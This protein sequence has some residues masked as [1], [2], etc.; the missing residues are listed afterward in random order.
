MQV[1]LLVS[2]QVI[3]KIIK[4][5]QPHK[6]GERADQGQRGNL[7]PLT[8]PE[9]IETD[10]MEPRLLIVPSQILDHIAAPSQVLD[11]ATAPAGPRPHVVTYTE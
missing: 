6:D 9:P 5:P 10:A 1:D 7:S 2:L 8:K 11:H 4:N 3:Y